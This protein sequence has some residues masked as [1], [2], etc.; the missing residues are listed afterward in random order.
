MGGSVL[1]ILSFAAGF[2]LVATGAFDVYVGLVKGGAIAASNAEVA[3]SFMLLFPGYVFLAYS[4]HPS[5]S[6]T[7]LGAIRRHGDQ[8][9]MSEPPIRPEDLPENVIAFPGQPLDRDPGAPGVK[10]YR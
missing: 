1:K 10:R 9:S 8:L 6:L 5:V 7:S 3:R 4:L 2:S